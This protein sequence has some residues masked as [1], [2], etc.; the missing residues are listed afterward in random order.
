VSRFFGP[1]RLESRNKCE[2]G[3]RG[4]SKEE[5]QEEHTI[6]GGG[7]GGGGKKR[8]TKKKQGEPKPNLGRLKKGGWAD[9]KCLRGGDRGCLRGILLLVYAERRKGELKRK[10][11]GAGGG[12]WIGRGLLDVPLAGTQWGVGK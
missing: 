6:D 8:E 10:R 11:V 12:D 4:T 7:R 5:G 3:L 2:E 9:K 1:E